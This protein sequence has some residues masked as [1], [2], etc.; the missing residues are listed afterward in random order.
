MPAILWRLPDYRA[1]PSCPPTKAGPETTR[2]DSGDEGSEDDP[3]ET[4]AE[5][6]AKRAKAR[7]EGGADPD[8]SAP[9]AG[10]WGAC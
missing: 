9:G 7:Q 1:R 3:Q 2:P 4:R 10:V 6:A 8:G 5:R